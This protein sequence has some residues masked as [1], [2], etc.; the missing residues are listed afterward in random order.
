MPNLTKGKEVLTLRKT[1][2]ELMLLAKNFRIVKVPKVW[3]TVPVSDRYN[4]M[5]LE[6]LCWAGRHNG[7]CS[8][9]VAVN[10]HEGYIDLNVMLQP[11]DTPKKSNRAKKLHYMQKQPKHSHRSSA[12]S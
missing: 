8:H 11:V 1:Y 6:C 5:H 9:I 10:G 2:A 3:E 7:I 4:P 12:M